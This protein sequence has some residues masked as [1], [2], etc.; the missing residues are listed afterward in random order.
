VD[1]PGGGDDVSGP[2]AGAPVVATTT[3]RI[4]GAERDGVRVWRGVP[5]A[6][7]PV[8]TRRFELPAPHPGWTGVRAC[9][10]PGPAPLQPTAPTTGVTVPGMAVGETSED[11][12][13][14][15]VWAPVGA[16]GA[17]V[18]VWI[19]GGAFTIGAGSQPTYDGARLAAEGGV[20]VVAVTYRL[21]FLGFSALP[22]GPAN[23]G[24]VD[25]AAALAWVQ[26]NARSFGGDPDRVT[27]FGE[28]AGGGSICHLLAARL[29][30]GL[31]RRAVVQSGA[32]GFTQTLD[33]A[34]A[35]TE[36][37]LAAGD[38]RAMHAAALLAAQDAA[39]ADLVPTY[40]A[41]PFHPCVDG[42]VVK[43]TPY[44]AVAAGDA[45]GVDLLIGT[46]AHEMRLYVDVRE[47]LSRERLQRRLAAVAGSE[48]GGD[49]LLAAY[50][51]EGGA[52]TL[53]HLWSD[54]R[55]DADLATWAERLAAAQ[56][57]HQPSTYR[58]VFTYESAVEGGRLGACHAVDLP[59]T[60]G[61]FD[62]DGWD[63]FVGGGADAERVGRELRAAWAAFAHTGTPGP[64]WPAYD[65]SRR[66][67]RL[68]G[69][70]ST[71]ADDPRGGIRD[72]WAEVRPVP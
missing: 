62:V 57:K 66:A 10:A 51:T 14:L 56:S 50:E 54:V 7:P 8:G 64:D 22:D 70:E 18:M 17:P 24:L 46:T 48:A 60:F 69:R 23:L 63:A 36:R 26:E 53:A 45:A 16:D 71:V 49:R 40:G 11:C 33:Q 9:R 6:A 44:E 27:V 15:D 29:A 2:A 72:A 65:T 3:G 34:R 38:V 20:V 13:H 59:F 12:L 52:P 55:T 47:D 39:L 28:S 5:Y 4:E 31:F 1:L 19:P 32:T 41:M 30:R 58:Y 35:A 61:T 68:I 21:G 43:R 37:M 67:T 42:G 25:Q